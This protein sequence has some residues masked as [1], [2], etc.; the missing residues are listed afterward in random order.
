[1]A[2]LRKWPFAEINERI[3][4]EDKP[5]VGLEYEGTFNVAR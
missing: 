2:R 4:R 5:L 3:E 1:M